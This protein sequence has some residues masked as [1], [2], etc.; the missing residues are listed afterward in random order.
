MEFKRP[1]NFEDILNLQKYLDKSIHSARERTEED[2]KTSMI[3]E[4]KKQK[5][6][7][8]LGKLNLITKL[9]NLKN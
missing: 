7:I 3:A 4:L 1:E 2:V 9:M 6:V 8:K 5:I